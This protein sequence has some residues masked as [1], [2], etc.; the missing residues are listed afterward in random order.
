[1]ITRSKQNWEAGNIVKVG[2]MQLRV[3]QA[4]PTPGDYMPDAYI[5]TNLASTKLYKFVPH[6]G[7]E[8]IDLEEANEMIASAVEIAAEKAK[9]AI[10]TAR[11]TI[12]ITRLI[13]K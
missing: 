8:S 2:F 9:I 5:L 13:A 3:V 6:N 4:I 7:L 10:N 12:E 11:Q 1:M